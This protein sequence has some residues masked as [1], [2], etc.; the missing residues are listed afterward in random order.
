MVYKTFKPQRWIDRRV[1][2]E[3]GKEAYDNGAG[4][5]GPKNLWEGATRSNALFLSTAV[6]LNSEALW[7][8][9]DWFASGLVIFNEIAHLGPQ[10]SIQMLQHYCPVK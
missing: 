9:F 1:D 3:T 8:V 10:F 6:Q 2:P 4:L 7:P 5:K